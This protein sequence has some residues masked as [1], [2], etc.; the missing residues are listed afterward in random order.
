MFELLPHGVPYTLDLLRHSLAAR[1]RAVQVPLT[2]FVATKG[3]LTGVREAG[4]AGEWSELGVREAYPDASVVF[5]ERYALH[6][7]GFD[8]TCGQTAE[9]VK[10]RYDIFVTC[11]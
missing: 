2:L 3:I 6:D 4:N 11:T 5:V 7:A 9:L 10:T 8:C 1:L